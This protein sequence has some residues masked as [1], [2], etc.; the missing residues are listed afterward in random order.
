M[1]R[2]AGGI[3]PNEKDVVTV[4]GVMGNYQG[5]RAVLNSTVTR[6]GVGNGAVPGPLCIINRNLGG[7]TTGYVPGVVNGIGLNNVGLLVREIGAI[8]Y[9]G[10]DY[11]YID[12]GSNVPGADGQI[13]IKVYCPGLTKPNP[14][15]THAIVTGICTIELDGS[16]PRPRLRP[17]KQADLTYY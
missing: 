8:T 14:T 6:T 7:A 1:V 16:T 12:D 2:I 3:Q 15:K 11:F 5:E 13:G 17:R 10:T 9:I 4:Q